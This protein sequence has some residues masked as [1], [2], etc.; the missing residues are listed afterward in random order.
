MIEKAE[1][2][3]VDDDNVERGGRRIERKRKIMRR[4]RRSVYTIG[5]GRLKRS[6]RLRYFIT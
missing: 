1:W 4:S 2:K 3:E 5:C 6:E